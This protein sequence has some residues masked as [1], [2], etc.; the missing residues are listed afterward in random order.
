MA[1]GWQRGELSAEF[2]EAARNAMTVLDSASLAAIGAWIAEGV[3]VDGILEEFP[4]PEEAAVV[5][6]L[7]SAFEDTE[8]S[9]DAAGAYLAGLAAGYAGGA[10][11]Q[12]I[13]VVWSGPSTARVPVRATSQVVQDVIAGA[14]HELLLMTYSAK[15]YESVL[16]ALK[17]AVARGVKTS[18]V[19]ETLLGAG[20]AISG[21]EPASAFA[22]VAGLELWHWP[23]TAR[24]EAGAKMHAKLVVAD[25]STLFST[26]ANLTASGVGKNIEAG[27][28][29]HGGEEP[30]RAAEHVAAL[31]SGGILQRLYP[32]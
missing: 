6:A 17:A 28:L 8:P 26:S 15:P 2:V 18:V 16:A 23:V 30:R 25:R 14:R 9:W 31:Q 1:A 4:L 3:S 27:L 22:S 32:G 5:E 7:M 13:Q 29:V 12:R 19:V 20:G 24:M 11:R 10:A 21:A